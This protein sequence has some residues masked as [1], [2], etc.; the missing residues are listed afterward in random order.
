V[1]FKAPGQ[2][3]ADG[4]SK[5]RE[6]GLTDSEFDLIVE[7]M[8]REPN[9]VELAM[10]SLLWSEHCAYKHSKKL[11]SS[12]PTEGPRV[13]MGPGEN[14]GA[15]DIGNGH[16]IAF[17]VES[18]NHPSAVEPFQGAATGVGG[19]LRDVI[20]LGARP[21]AMLDSLRFGELETERTR[22]LVDGVVR[23][24]GHYGNSMGIPTVG[25]EIYFEP[26]YELNP[27]VNAMCVGIA[28]TDEMVR[29]AAAGVG[30]KV[31]LIGSLTG[32]DGIGGASVLAS[33][34]LE[35]EDSSKRPT[36]QIGD[37]FEESKVLECCQELLGQELLVSLQ[38]LGAAG[39]T[40]SAGEM[41]SAGGVGIDIDVA[42]V[43][44]R[45]SDMEPFEIMV[46][47]SQ[48]RMLAVVE[49]ARVKEVLAI[50]SKWQTASA[51]I[52]EVTG[53][54]T[55]RILKDARTVGEIEVDDL[56]DGC[57]LYDLD[58]MPPSEWI[59]GNRVTLRDGAD[60]SEILLSL[61][62]SPSIASKR[63]AYEQYDSL[64]G[65]RTIRP[66][67]AADAAVLNIPEAERAIAIA[68]DGNGRRVAC[69]PLL[70]TIENTFECASNLAC[71]GAEPLGVTNCLNFGNPE[72]PTV[73]WQLSESVKGL[74][75]ACRALDL[76]VVG[77]NV[78]LYNETPSGP[79]YPTPV[80]GMVGELP[81]PSS[82]GSEAWRDGDSIAFVGPLS[83][84]LAGS[85]LEK[86]R[87]ELGQGLPGFDTA[88]IRKALELIRDCV[89]SGSIRTAHDVSDGGIATAIAELAIASNLGCDATLNPVIAQH[90]CGDEDA[91]FGE[92]PGGFI[93]AGT[94]QEIEH[95]GGRD[96]QVEFLGTV[97]GD[98]VEVTAGEH[99]VKVLLPEARAAF[100]SLAS[101]L[102]P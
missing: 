29:A 43:P 95:L 97:G 34:E 6:L 2:T 89:R 59:Y 101:R 91:L 7:K 72:K 16:S 5:H 48:E 66:S 88:E 14:A 74:G 37:P 67:G 38:D 61:L 64:V 18:H 39:L 35:E 84:S 50:C 85:E 25:G 28:R 15:V 45:E 54:G 69:D 56:V 41:A 13:V 73:A 87:G 81:D 98:L 82:C 49:P 11:L 63:W 22:Y 8:G 27:L 90:G 99:Q 12:L 51:V 79:I 31:V 19:I 23:G 60:A 80:V 24:I 58:P 44:L 65:S 52:G 62:A 17:K 26:P 93:V 86:L 10:F 71:V 1:I 100:E 70:G 76:P 21:I 102:E 53:S 47:E 96:V 30:N 94:R 40:S 78:S 75:E 77:G 55:F 20:A 32:R 92:G 36:V 57:P 46:S 4:S 68:I 9:G 42:L 3:V 83:P 33:A